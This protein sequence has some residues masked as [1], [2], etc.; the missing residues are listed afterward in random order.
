MDLAWGLAFLCDVFADIRLAFLCEVVADV[1]YS[2]DVRHVHH[3]LQYR[4]RSLPAVG[5]GFFEVFDA[6][7]FRHHPGL[8]CGVAHGYC[9]RQVLDVRHLRYR[10]ECGYSFLHAACSCQV[11]DVCPSWRQVM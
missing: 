6:H 7:H 1:Q 8:S 3:L 2:D 5:W 10:L 9:S 4:R 11:P